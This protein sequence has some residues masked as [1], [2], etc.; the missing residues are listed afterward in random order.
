MENQYEKYCHNCG[1]IIDKRT[2]LCPKCGARQ[3]N[4]QNAQ[5]NVNIN[6]NQRWLITVL[7]CGF[8]GVFGAHRF[9]TNHI[10]SGILQL[11][12]CGGLGIWWII[13]LILIIIG[14]FKD[15]EGNY[16]KM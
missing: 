16:I 5:T 8:L 15:K 1:A 11:I 2:D 10:L 9:F 3:A 6:V 14:Q 4:F 13:D 12:T 7:L